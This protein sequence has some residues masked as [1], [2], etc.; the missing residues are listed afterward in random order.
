[1]YT[2]NELHSIEQSSLIPPFTIW[3][4]CPVCFLC[5][6]ELQNVWVPWNAAYRTDLLL[7][8]YNIKHC[9]IK[10]HV[11]LDRINPLNYIPSSQFLCR[12]RPHVA[13]RLLD[14]KASSSLLCSVSGVR[15]GLKPFKYLPIHFVLQSE[16]KGYC[17]VVVYVVLSW[18]NELMFTLPMHLRC[19]KGEKFEIVCQDLFSCCLFPGL[20]LCLSQRHG[21]IKDRVLWSKPRCL[22]SLGRVSSCTSD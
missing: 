15:W 16:T 22:V 2:V 7:D 1:M 9:K 3:P 17:G 13:H 6:C 10:R 4:L 21:S 5:V 8:I 11:K 20:L 19:C 14:E 18:V 12:R